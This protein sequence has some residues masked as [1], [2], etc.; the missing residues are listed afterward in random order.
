MNELCKTHHCAIPEKKSTANE[1][2][3]KDNNINKDII[4]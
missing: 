1:V 3:Y 2:G 4:A